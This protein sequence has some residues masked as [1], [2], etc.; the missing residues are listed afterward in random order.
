MGGRREEGEVYSL[1]RPE[2]AASFSPQMD[3]LP[4]TRC[5]VTR[6]SRGGRDSSRL[7]YYLHKINVDIFL[8]WERPAL[9]CYN[10][11]AGMDLVHIPPLLELKQV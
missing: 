10:S 5:H 4:V 9:V 8:E 3:G 6:I 11:V 7:R 2:N 1:Y